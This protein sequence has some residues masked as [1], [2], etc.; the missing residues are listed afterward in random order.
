M[1]NFDDVK[2]FMHAFGQEVKV[3][4]KVPQMKKLLNYVM[5]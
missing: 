4:A 3:K 5:S 2:T 1:S